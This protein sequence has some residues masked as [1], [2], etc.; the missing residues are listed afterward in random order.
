MKLIIPHPVVVA[1]DKCSFSELLLCSWR[2]RWSLRHSALLFCHRHF[3]L[4]PDGGQYYDPTPFCCFMMIC[5]QL[6]G[7][8]APPV[9][10]CWISCVLQSS[11]LCVQPPSTNFLWPQKNDTGVFSFCAGVATHVWQKRCVWSLLKVAR[12]TEDFAQ[13][14]KPGG[15]PSCWRLRGL[16]SSCWTSLAWFL[17]CT[18]KFPSHSPHKTWGKLLYGFFFFFF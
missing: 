3:R 4:P 11:D 6:N 10:S 15:G 13:R 8:E 12:T 1:R 18:S 5:E 16:L 2:H 17:V 14:L 9:R 7:W